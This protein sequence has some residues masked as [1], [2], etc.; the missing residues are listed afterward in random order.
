[1]D[2]FI[3]IL[4]TP[5]FKAGDKPPENGGY[6]E[7]HEWADVQRKA[8]ITQGLCKCG[9]WITPQE[10]EDHKGCYRT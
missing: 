2:N 10:N 8:G 6:L 5:F 1:M 4:V 7:W 3:C 9:K